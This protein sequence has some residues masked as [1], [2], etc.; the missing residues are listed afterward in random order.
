MGGD[1]DAEAGEEQWLRY[2][3]ETIATKGEK[4]GPAWAVQ[5]LHTLHVEAHEL[6]EQRRAE[7]EEA[8]APE[9]QAEVDG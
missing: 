3:Q 2:F 6:L 8:P 7:S 5:L 4:K 9:G 1:T